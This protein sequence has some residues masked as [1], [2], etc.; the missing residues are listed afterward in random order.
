MQLVYFVR[1]CEIYTDYKGY[2]EMNTTIEGS[3]ELVFSHVT[4]FP[5]VENISLR[6]NPTIRLSI[7]MKEIINELKEVVIT[8]SRKDWE[9]YLNIFKKE[10]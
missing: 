5:V 3:H 6:N 7:S 8:D 10:A 1:F 2:F 9:K 4:H